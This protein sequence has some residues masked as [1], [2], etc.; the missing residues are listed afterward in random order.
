MLEVGMV[1]N[2]CG[3]SC[4]GTLELTLSQKWTDGKLKV[5]SMIFGWVWSKMV[6]AFSDH[7][8]QKSAVS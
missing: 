6:V 5:D 1:R 3:Q 7:G 8:T 2:M 4:D